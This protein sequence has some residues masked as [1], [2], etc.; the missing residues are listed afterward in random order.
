MVKGPWDV[1]WNPAQWTKIMWRPEDVASEFW[2][3]RGVVKPIK[4]PWY[5]SLKWP[6][7]QVKQYKELGIQ[8]WL[9]EKMWKWAQPGTTGLSKLRWSV[10]GVDAALFLL[11]YEM[12]AVSFTEFIYYEGVRWG[13]KLLRIVKKH[14]NWEGLVYFAD[15]FVGD[16]WRPAYGFHVIYGPLNPWSVNGYQVMYEYYWE[17]FMDLMEGSGIITGGSRD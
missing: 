8:T 2:K 3:S 12:E 1:V 11:A 13:I 10:V 9:N 14:E 4:P 17:E 7:P 6:T 15:K 16:V 5:K